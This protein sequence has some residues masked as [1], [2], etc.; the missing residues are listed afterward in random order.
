MCTLV[1]ENKSAVLTQMDQY[2]RRMFGIPIYALTMKQVMQV[3]DETIRSRSQLLIGVVNAA[4]VVNM[5]R[6]PSLRDAV[7]ASNLILA[8]GMSVVWASRLLGEPL[9]ERVTGVD[10][11]MR[12]LELANER[13]YRIY[14]LGASQEVLETVMQ[15]IAE[16][17]PNARLVGR[18]HGYFSQ[19]NELHLADEIAAAE[20]DMLFVAMSPPKKEIFLAR[21][22]RQMN[23]PVSHGVGG[24]FDI[25]A[26]KTRRAPR[27]WQKLGMEWLYRVCQEPRRMWRRYLVTNTLFCG[28]VLSELV[29]RFWSRLNPRKTNHTHD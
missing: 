12:M 14:C 13:G 15:R 9:P 5:R 22:A 20:P 16:L 29:R 23:V 4:K 18:H 27:I 11:M 2:V 19:E 3:I 25:L 1:T 24:A 7:L 26:G 28:I 10:L 8:D 6:H 21:W 17:F